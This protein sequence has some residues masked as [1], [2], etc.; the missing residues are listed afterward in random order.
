MKTF[1]LRCKKCNKQGALRIYKP[2]KLGD[3]K[4]ITRCPACN[5]V[6]AVILVETLPRFQRPLGDDNDN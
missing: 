6:R 1:S 2:K 4:F 5:H 3:D